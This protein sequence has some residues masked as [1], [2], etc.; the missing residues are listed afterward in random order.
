MQAGMLYYL[1]FPGLFPYISRHSLLQLQSTFSMVSRHSSQVYTAPAQ[2][3]NLSLPR[4]TGLTIFKQ[5]S[6][7][8]TIFAS[9]LW[10]TSVFQTVSGIWVKQLSGWL[11]S[12]INGLSWLCKSSNLHDGSLSWGRKTNFLSDYPST[13]PVLTE[14]RQAIMWPLKALSKSCA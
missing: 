14:R 12:W 8:K 2:N 6:G 9:K 1:T 10:S 7:F 13:R 4:K 11:R 3:E 5:W